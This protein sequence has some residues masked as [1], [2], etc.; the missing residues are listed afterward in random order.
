ML[1]S[2]YKCLVLFL[3]QMQVV[4]TNRLPVATGRSEANA[5]RTQVT[6]KETAVFGAT[7]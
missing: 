7:I 5:K 4:L 1:Y 3:S 6:W 2:D